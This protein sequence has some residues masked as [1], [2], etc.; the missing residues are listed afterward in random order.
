MAVSENDFLRLE[1]DV[2]SLRTDVNQLQTAGAVENERHKSIVKRLDRIDGHINKLMW[3]II[4][5][6]IG[7]LMQ[8]MFSGGLNAGS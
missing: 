5:A 8:F 6:I 7:G 4:A 3:L 1:G 2:R